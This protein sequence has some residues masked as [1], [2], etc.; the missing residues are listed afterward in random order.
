MCVSVCVFVCVFMYMFVYT[1]QYSTI[2]F[3]ISFLFEPRG[4][5]K[6]IHDKTPMVLSNVLVKDLL[7]VP[8]R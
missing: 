6:T 1:I 5:H 7:K 4:A 3:D 8:A 2:A